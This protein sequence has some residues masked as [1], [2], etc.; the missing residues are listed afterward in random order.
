MFVKCVKGHPEVLEEE[1]I[2]EVEDITPLGD[3]KLLGVLP[4]SPYTCFKK[5][6][7]TPINFDDINIEEVFEFV[8]EI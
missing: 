1:Q 4:P 3:F 2:Y 6:R 5:E 8:M 7:F